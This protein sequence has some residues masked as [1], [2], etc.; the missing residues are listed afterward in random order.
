MYGLSRN[1]Y[2]NNRYPQILWMP[3]K[4]ELQIS[5]SD[6]L[7]LVSHG[8]NIDSKFQFRQYK[9]EKHVS[10]FYVEWA[11]VQMSFFFRAGKR[12]QSGWEDEAL[13]GM[14]TAL[15]AVVL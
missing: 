4:I 2:K 14:K 7:N 6:V 9:Q 8:N 15:A 5:F 1:N 13:V 10:Q 12:F 11:P 3:N